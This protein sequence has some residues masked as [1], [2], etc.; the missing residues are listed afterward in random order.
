MLQRSAEQNL[1]F[2]VLFVHGL[3]S[4]SRTW[5]KTVSAFIEDYDLRY[6]GTVSANPPSGQ[7]QPTPADFIRGTSRAT[8]ICHTESRQKSLLQALKLYAA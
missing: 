6:G 1:K 8:T 7:L 2:P 4:S 5:T 3:F